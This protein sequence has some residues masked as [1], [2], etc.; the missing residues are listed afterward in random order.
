MNAKGLPGTKGMVDRQ[1]SKLLALGS[2]LE[3]KTRELG[4]IQ[5]RHDDCPSYETTLKQ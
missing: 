5:P 4:N 2:E 1:P 3:G